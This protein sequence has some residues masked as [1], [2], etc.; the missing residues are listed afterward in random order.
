MDTTL[1]CSLRPGSVPA[2]VLPVSELRVLSA[3]A[4]AGR[5]ERSFGHEQLGAVLERQPA[6]AGQIDRDVVGNGG[7]RRQELDVGVQRTDEPQITVEETLHAER[8]WA[9]P[10]VLAPVAT[11][12]QRSAAELVAHDIARLP[13]CCREPTRPGGSR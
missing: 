4:G 8:V 2:A 10:N 9:G 6:H 3:P 1:D 7:W 13:G 12:P 5:G 11:Q